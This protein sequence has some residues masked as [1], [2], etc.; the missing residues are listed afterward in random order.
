MS[1][2]FNA[3]KRFEEIASVYAGP[4]DPQIARN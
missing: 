4:D 2:V 1:L 3:A